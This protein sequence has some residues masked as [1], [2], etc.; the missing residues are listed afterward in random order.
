MCSWVCVCVCVFQEYMCL[1]EWYKICQ[2]CL[3]TICCLPVR[4]WLSD[5][6]IELFLFRCLMYGRCFYLCCFKTQ[7]NTGF[8]VINLLFLLFLIYFFINWMIT[9]QSACWSNL[10]P[11]VLSTSILLKSYVTKIII[12]INI[13]CFAKRS[14]FSWHF[15]PLL[16]TDMKVAI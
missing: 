8:Y 3:K 1:P 16:M 5:L 6:V 11:I 4:F 9:P 14:T 15:T 12:I 7:S 10:M 13:E 2:Q